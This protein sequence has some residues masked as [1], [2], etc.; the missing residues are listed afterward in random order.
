M[1][2]D[3]TLPTRPLVFTQ[4]MTPFSICDYWSDHDWFCAALKPRTYYVESWSSSQY[5]Q[6]EGAFKT[7][8]GVDIRNSVTN[9]HEDASWLLFYVGM[10]VWMF[11]LSTLY[12]FFYRNSAANFRSRVKAYKAGSK[13]RLEHSAPSVFPL[14]RYIVAWLFLWSVFFAQVSLRGNLP[15]YFFVPHQDVVHSYK[16]RVASCI[17]QWLRFVRECVKII[18][19]YFLCL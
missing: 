15:D 1:D 17:E 18:V 2:N 4:A 10:K 5:L 14:V 16:M 12:I 7:C 19:R 11:C 3:W 13:R 8:S 6:T 9:V